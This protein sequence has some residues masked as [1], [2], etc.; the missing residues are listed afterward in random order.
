MNP[1]VKMR[2]TSHSYRTNTVKQGGKTPIFNEDFYF[3]INSE[4]ISHG[5]IL[6]LAVVDE[7]AT[8]NSEVG[9]GIVDCD[10][11]IMNKLSSLNQKCYIVYN[12]KPAGYVNLHFSFQEEFIGVLFIHILNA[13]IRRK[14]TTLSNMVCQ[15]R[16]SIG[17]EILTTEKS[18]DTKNE[19]PHWAQVF[20]VPIIRS[21]ETGVI[22]ILEVGSGAETAVGD[23]EIGIKELIEPSG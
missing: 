11:V 5:R 20:H 13:S 17:E 7:G 9:Y 14:T 2:L 1:F 18:K 22:E 8:F 4:S 3:F 19:A 23:C 21:I 16:I 12:Q 15:A 10:P 6:E